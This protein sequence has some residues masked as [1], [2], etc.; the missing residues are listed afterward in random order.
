MSAFD[1]RHGWVIFP[2]FSRENGFEKTRK[3]PTSLWLALRDPRR[4]VLTGVT[5]GVLGSTEEARFAAKRDDL[6][7]EDRLFSSIKLFRTENGT[8]G[9]KI[10]KK[11]EKRVK[12]FF[13][14]AQAMA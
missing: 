12:T 8:F 5:K 4:G 7:I 6:R 1:D 13:L 11:D 10:Q 14:S 9:A 2:E 3:D